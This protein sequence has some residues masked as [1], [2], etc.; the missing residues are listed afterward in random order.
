MDRSGG[1]VE[2]ENGS[3]LG[4]A[5]MGGLG[6]LTVACV[7]GLTASVALAQGGMPVS[8]DGTDPATWD[9][10]QDALKAAPANHQVLF[11]NDAIRVLSVSIRPGERE[12]VHHHRWP[13]VMVVDALGPL[14]DYDANGREQKLPLPDSIE[15]PL[16]LELP[17]QA[18]HAA[19]NLDTEP[20]HAIRIE[21]KQGSFQR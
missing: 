12:E 15:R 17:P 3:H 14:K 21:F 16:V 8:T 6:Y 10:A 18:A 19:E 1:I 13:S 2:I 9:P 20:F 7:L 11:E 4:E 5:P